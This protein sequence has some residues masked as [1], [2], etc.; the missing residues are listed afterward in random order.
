MYHPDVFF[1]YWKVITMKIHNPNIS[2]DIG[3]MNFH[4]I[5]TV[6]FHQHWTLYILDLGTNKIFLKSS[7]YKNYVSGR[8]ISIILGLYVF[9]NIVTTYYCDPGTSTI[10]AKSFRYKHYILGQYI[11]IIL[12]LYVLAISGLYIFVT[13]GRARFL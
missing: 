7:H 5:E 4:Y 9:F 10:F 12:G 2:F 8:Y 1:L 13:L 3:M 11:L 6:R